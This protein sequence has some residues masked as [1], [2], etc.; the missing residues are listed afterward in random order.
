MSVT[1]ALEDD[2]DLGRD[3]A[4]M[5]RGRIRLVRDHADVARALTAVFAE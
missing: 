4:R 2:V 3:L 5:G 1:P